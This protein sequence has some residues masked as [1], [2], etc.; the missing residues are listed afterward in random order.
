MIAAAPAWC[1]EFIGKPYADHGRGPAAFDCYGLALAVM[2]RLGIVPP[3]YA[4]LY[5]HAED[6]AAVAGC[7]AQAAPGWQ[8]VPV[9]ELRAGDLIVLRVAGLP[10]HVGVVVAP[11]LMLHTLRGR[12][13]VL[14]SYTTRAWAGRIVEA[15]RWTA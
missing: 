9:A 11:G 4:A 8:A 14:E 7:I 6:D 1:A 13:A 12:D 15:L 2:R 3:D 5:A 10:V